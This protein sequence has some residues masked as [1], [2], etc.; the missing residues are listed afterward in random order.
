LVGARIDVNAI[1]QANAFDQAMHVATL[2]RTYQTDIERI[3]L[4]CHWIIEH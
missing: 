4:V 3:I 2:L 1:D